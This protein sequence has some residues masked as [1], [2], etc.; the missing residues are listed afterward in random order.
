MT[1]LPSVETT[2]FLLLCIAFDVKS[3]PFRWHMLTVWMWN[4][5]CSVP[6]PV[7]LSLPS[8][9][10]I[11]RGFDQVYVA[12][13]LHF[14]WGTTEVPGSE[15]TID[16]VHFPAEVSRGG[17]HLMVSVKL[18]LLSH[19]QPFLENYNDLLSFRDHVEKC[20]LVNHFWLFQRWEGKLSL[21]E[22]SLPVGVL[23]R[24]GLL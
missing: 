7:K 2:L 24:S 6:L 11:V 9:M 10:R 8:S 22:Q 18:E 13:Q 21:C 15:H 14:H 3:P 4:A 1:L 23:M 16:N 19:T 12:A 20:I 5:C 17:G